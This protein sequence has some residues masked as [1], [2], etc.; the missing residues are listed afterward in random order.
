MMSTIRVFSA[1]IF[2]F[3]SFSS[4]AQDAHE[5]LE[6]VQDTLQEEIDGIEDNLLLDTTEFFSDPVLPP[7]PDSVVKYDNTDVT[8]R[9]AEEGKIDDLKKDPDLDYTITPNVQSIWS[10]LSWWLGSL[11]F[12]LFSEGGDGAWLRYLFWTIGVIILI[13]VIL[14]LLKIDALK[15]FYS[16]KG[17]SITYTAIDEDIHEMDFEKLIA[18]AIASN[19]YRLAIRLQFLQALKILSDKHLIH[20]HPGK[21]NHDYMLELGKSNLRDGFAE[22][23]GYF[24]YAWYGNF[25]IAPELFSKVQTIFNTWR[26]QA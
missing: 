13:Y 15:V 1:I 25:P 24:E 23:N 22:L 10:A 5:E 8:V 17:K 20:W 6:Q 26:R 11:F 16:G 2:I 12:S 4:K 3:C 7:L 18:N 14:R 9:K 21:T 19:D